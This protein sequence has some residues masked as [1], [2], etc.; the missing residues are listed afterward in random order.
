MGLF[1]RKKK[2]ETKEEKAR[3]E[4]RQLAQDYPDYVFGSVYCELSGTYRKPYISAANK[5]E[6]KKRLQQR[7]GSF[8]IEPDEE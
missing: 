3:R 6:L 2:E 4:M 8:I 7:S 5:D 1:K